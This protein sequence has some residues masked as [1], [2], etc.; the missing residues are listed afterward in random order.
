MAEPEND[1][2]PSP[3]EITTYLEKL[4]KLVALVAEAIRSDNRVRLILLFGI[5]F[6][7]FFD[8]LY[9]FVTG[10]PLT[11]NY[12]FS[13]LSIILPTF[14]IAVAVAAVTQPKKVRKPA[15]EFA[16]RSPIKGLLPF[17]SSDANLFSLLQREDFLRDCLQNITANNFRFGVLYGESGVGKTS[18]LRAGVL[19]RLRARK[20]RCVYVSLS[21][22]NPAESIGQALVQELRLPNGGSGRVDLH[23]LLN[24]GAP[25]DAEP[26]VLILD[27]FE[28]IFVHHKSKSNPFF[29]ELANWYQKGPV[30]PVK[31][32]L[33]VRS[34]F[35]LRMLQLLNLMGC[36]LG[37]QQSW[38]L[39]KLEPDQAAEILR[40][41]AD[42]EQIALD[43][44]FLRTLTSE[45]AGLEDG[46]ISPVNIQIWA[47]MVAV[48]GRGGERA[49][50]R[51]A[52]QRLGGIEGL[53]EKYLSRI[54]GTRETKNRREAA[55][56]VLLALTDLGRNTRAGAL[57]LKDLSDQLAGT[58]TAADIG[59]AV[60]WLER[61][62][63][64][65]IVPVKRNG[66]EGYELAHERLIPAV[67]R[68]AGEYVT[69]AGRANQL[70]DRRVNE[71]LANDR[72]PRYLFSWREWLLIR[73][74]KERLEW[75]KQQTFKEDLLARS[76]RRLLK[77]TLV[78]T[79]PLILFIISQFIFGY[80]SLERDYADRI[81]VRQGFSL[82]G[83]L[84]LLG[85]K[86]ILDTDFK[87]EDL[88]PEKR[89][90]LEGSLYY[91]WGNHLSGVLGDKRFSD[92][93]RLPVTKGL[94]LCQVGEEEEGISIIQGEIKHSKTPYGR[95]RDEL[96]ALKQV[97]QAKP[98][99][100]DRVF[101]S[102][103]LALSTLQKEELRDVTPALEQ[104]GR[105]NPRL[106]LEPML[107]TLNDPD[108]EIRWASLSALQRAAQANPELL[109]E[110][111]LSELANGTEY[112]KWGSASVL[113]RAAQSSP[114]SANRIAAAL[115]PALKD[116]DG[117]V[118]ASAASALGRAVEADPALA[119]RVVDPLLIALTDK[120]VTARW[121]AA[122]GLN[123]VIKA[124]PKV[125]ARTVDS[126][127]KTLEDEN[128]QVRKYAVAALGLTAQADHG[129]AG[130]ILDALLTAM[131]KKPEAQAAS[132]DSGPGVRPYY[133][134][135]DVRTTSRALE[136]AAS[137]NPKLALESLRAVH[138]DDSYVVS[139][140][141]I[142]A[143]G[144]VALAD[145]SLA[146]DVI[147]EL[148]MMSDQVKESTGELPKAFARVAQVAPKR[149]LE[150]LLDML[151]SDDPLRMVVAVPALGRAA[152]ADLGL[153]DRIVDR[154]LPALEDDD[155]QVRISVARTLGQ[156][157]HASPV[158]VN[159]V[160][161]PLLRALKDSNP[162]VR[163]AA[164]GALGEIAEVDDNT[165][166]R[167]FHLLTDYDA[168]V[169]DE[170]R[171]HFVN[172][173]LTQAEKEERHGEF[174]LDH[175]D[176]R[177]LLMGTG[178]VNAHAVYR[179]V[180]ISALAQWLTPDKPKPDAHQDVI[181]HKLEEMRDNDKRL[182]LRIAA[183]DVFSEAAER[184]EKLEKDGE[185]E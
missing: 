22:L 44:N 170:V 185:E 73:R 111:M 150:P 85:D 179:H 157:V 47:Q 184:R 160:L 39:E 143:L 162:E 71:W 105:A 68:E 64:R 109:V 127:L 27:Q 133:L 8:S 87:I 107:K 149:A 60:T 122:V 10:N 15:H 116:S 28:Q 161:E 97:V 136:R 61:A 24:V 101:Q 78:S 120:H 175:L 163:R 103:L 145:P 156:V 3:E 5:L 159:R 134:L 114:R 158:L 118:R 93:V 98:K 34:D 110:P 99:L 129:L 74:Q 168:S 9:K 6:A 95:S 16:A 7:A 82:F 183:W 55:V 171:P 166:G 174:L 90:E 23:T 1:K 37:P 21:E 41:I 131:Q 135:A 4:E 182:H 115:I 88:E 12:W 53:L 132:P 40:V 173:L 169:R 121:G 152:Q 104:V 94:L 119:E 70:L 77:R 66:A 130:R 153:A 14:I 165:R 49:F 177:R 52:Y 35:A 54:L 128:A 18:L 124:N 25:E 13:F 106:V 92:A 19:P 141:V 30:L 176:G 181:I 56:K 178:D 2:V 96:S 91:G 72:S 26:L 167:A 11:S 58:I 108:Y 83:S 81:V 79:L 17:E 86:V 84:P 172:I 57:T 140:P 164:A 117:D 62:D 59:E 138:Y 144:Q 29:Q 151:D 63:V 48:R 36:S 51:E 69:D 31:I 20:H 100:A 139:A 147:N 123:R 75:G 45:L 137:A 46:L 50:N 125:A 33:S 155:A 89:D 67:R 65:L 42:E 180:V 112:T 154:L 80:L 76:K 102:L 146:D 43:E 113:G 148:V 32:V 126:F 142:A 38:L